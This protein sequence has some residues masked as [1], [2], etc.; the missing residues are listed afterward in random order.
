MK[1]KFDESCGTAAGLSCIEPKV[2]TGR[3][4]SLTHN[5]KELP[6]LTF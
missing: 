5:G 6:F 2:S 3:L 4:Q 1:V